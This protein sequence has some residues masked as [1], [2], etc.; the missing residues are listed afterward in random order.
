MHTPGHAHEPAPQPV[1][2][3]WR[4]F[5]TH[6]RKLVALLVWLTLLVCYNWYTTSNNLNP[7]EALR[8]LATVLQSP[9]GP[10]LFLLLFALRSLVFFSA[11]LLAVLAGCVFG[12]FWGI[13]ITLLAVSI[14]GSVAY[15]IGYLLGGDMCRYRPRSPVFRHYADSLQEHN[16]ETV[17]LMHLFFLP[18][19]LVNYLAGL[20]RIRYRAFALATLLG[21]IPGSIIFAT[22]GATLDLDDQRG[23]VLPRLQDVSSWQIA[24]ALGLFLSSITIAASLRWRIQRKSQQ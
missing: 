15:S 14:S 10:L 8:Q 22:F 24:L 2:R 9:L 11:S 3:L 6:W 16:F 13:A 4:L 1:S 7:L 19:D 12:P 17:L 23:G 20:L 21:W 5:R 18:F